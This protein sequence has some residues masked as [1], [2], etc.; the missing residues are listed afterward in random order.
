MPAA[1]KFKPIARLSIRMVSMDSSAPPARVAVRH[2]L[3][4]L[5]GVVAFVAATAGG[6][7]LHGL[8]KAPVG[9]GNGCDPIATG[10]DG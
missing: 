10:T 5:P 8:A 1:L 2:F 3:E 6:M 7:L 9:I 4:R